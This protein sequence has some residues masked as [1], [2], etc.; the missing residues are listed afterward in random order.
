MGGI[1]VQ[2]LSEREGDRVI[3][4]SCIRGR[5]VCLDGC[6]SESGNQFLDVS[7]ALSAG[8]RRAEGIVIPNRMFE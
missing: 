4:K 8:D 1:H 7:D 3:I 5:I 6:M 2:T